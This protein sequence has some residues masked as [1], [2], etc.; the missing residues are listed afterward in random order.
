MKS[1]L[2]SALLASAVLGLVS[3]ALTAP[4]HADTRYFDE[5]NSYAALPATVPVAYVGDAYGYNYAYYNYDGY[6]YG[7]APAPIAAMPV[8]YADPYMQGGWHYDGE[9][10]VP[11]RFANLT[12]HEE[13]LGTEWRT[14]VTVN[15][16]PILHGDNQ[17]SALHIS[18]PF[19]LYDEDAVI[20]TAARGDAACPV[21]NYLIIV[22]RDGSAPMPREIASCTNIHDAHI[23]HNTLFI[24]F[25]SV[26]NDSGWS[27]FDT[28]R[29]Q[30]S[31]LIRM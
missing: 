7:Y 12:V 27:T 21:R 10:R 1:I 6:N 23:D 13:N 30:N 28:W 18:Q 22:R 17:I 24:S 15:G 5:T 31:D 2:T 4:A 14:V 20:L 29:Y 16:T 19:Q 11:I 26:N 8:A 9:R 3:G 25:P